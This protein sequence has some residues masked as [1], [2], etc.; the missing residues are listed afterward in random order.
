[1]QMNFFLQCLIADGTEKAE[2][3]KGIKSFSFCLL[4]EFQSDEPELVI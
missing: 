4:K 1:M 2:E 3:E